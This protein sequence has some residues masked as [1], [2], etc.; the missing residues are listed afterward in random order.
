MTQEHTPGPWDV[1][2]DGEYAYLT[3]GGEVRASLLGSNRK[4]NAR[5]FG[6]ADDLLIALKAAAMS[7]G[8]QYMIYET[9][10]LIQA[11]IDRA[12]GRP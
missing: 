10:D 1:Y 11:A 5:L 2:Y 7:S 9:R 8:F 12:E 4:A 6:A 3:A